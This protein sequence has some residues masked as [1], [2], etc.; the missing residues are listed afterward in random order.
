MLCSGPV[1]GS[2]GPWAH[3]SPVSEPVLRLFL[4]LLL[5]LCGSY[6]S[7]LPLQRAPAMLPIALWAIPRGFRDWLPTSPGIDDL[8]W[9]PKWMVGT[10][11]QRQ[12]SVCSPTRSACCWAWSWWRMW[13]L[14]L[15]VLQRHL[16]C[17]VGGSCAGGSPGTPSWT[18]GPGSPQGLP[19]VLLRVS[20]WKCRAT[21]SHQ[22][23][24][25]IAFP[26]IGKQFKTHFERVH[27]CRTR[28]LI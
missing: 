1:C 16:C 4:L 12:P 3:P 17:L 11:G 5:L 27:S 18:E 25:L 23:P 10:L 7:T 21:L 26:S 19:G 8:F 24:L 28:R 13:A 15:E 6:P 20:Y 9:F 22:P 2:P 14:G